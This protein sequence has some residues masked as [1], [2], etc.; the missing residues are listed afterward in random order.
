MAE[1]AGRG[2]FAVCPASVCHILPGMWDPQWVFKPSALRPG[3]LNARPTLLKCW[4]TAPSSLC[5]SF[6][7]PSLSFSYFPSHR[8]NPVL[9]PLPSAPSLLIH[10]CSFSPFWPSAG[11]S[12]CLSLFPWGESANYGK[13]NRDSPDICWRVDSIEGIHSVVCG[14]A[15][16]EQQNDKLRG[17]RTRSGWSLIVQH[18]HCI[19]CAS[20]KTVLMN[21]KNSSMNKSLPNFPTTDEF[22]YI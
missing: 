10:P 8:L 6:F 19:L 18:K 1:C 2:N 15:E 20:V 14:N 5:V 21:T 7:F 22:S 13:M 9:F 17:P 3:H 12:A 16:R 4:L 11:L